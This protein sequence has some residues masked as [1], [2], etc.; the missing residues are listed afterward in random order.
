[1]FKVLIT[2]L[3]LNSYMSGIWLS[4]AQFVNLMDFH[5]NVKI[6]IAKD[7]ENFSM[8]KRYLYG[9]HYQ[10]SSLSLFSYSD[11]EENNFY[12]IHQKQRVYVTKRQY[13]EAKTYSKSKTKYIMVSYWGKAWKKKLYVVEG[14]LKKITDASI[15]DMMFT[16]RTAKFIIKQEK[17]T[18]YYAYLEDDT[19]LVN[20]LLNDSVFSIHLTLLYLRYNYDLAVKRNYSR[21]LERAVGKHNGGWNNFAYYNKIEKGI[22]DVQQ[23][24]VENMYEIDIMRYVNQRYSEL[25]GTK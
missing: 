19:K 8:F 12:Y 14:V 16:V 20:K 22:K 3:V 24:L 4:K 21:P 25:K 18:K 7:P 23:I 11:T 1:M 15:G 13:D 10:E 6:A 9:I 5:V 17:V 2:L